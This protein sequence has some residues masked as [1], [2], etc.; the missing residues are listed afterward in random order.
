MKKTLKLIS[1][2]L[3]SIIIVVLLLCLI[4][5]IVYFKTK[6]EGLSMY[7]T[8]NNQTKD[9]IFVNKFEKGSKGDIVVADTKYQENWNPPIST[10]QKEDER[11][12]IKS[13]VAVEGD[14]VKFERTDEINYSLIVNDIV[15]ATQEIYGL[16]STYEDFIDYVEINS[17]DNARIQ[18]GAIILQKD[19]IY[20]VGDNWQNSYDS[21]DCGPINKNSLVGRVDIIVP[22]DEN[23]IIG[24]IK[25]IFKQI[26]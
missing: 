25:G 23:L 1:Y 24:A 22:E 10:E 9:R 7:P 21:A 6:V 20:L 2:I 5:N 19:E 15:V 13:L 11:Y 4:F 3:L 14:I 26:F 16:C 17:S 12:V 8:L 18:N